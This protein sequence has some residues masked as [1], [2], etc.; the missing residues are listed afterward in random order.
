MQAVFHYHDAQTDDQLLTQAVVDSA[1]R[2]GAVVEYPARV[3]GLVQE[4]HACRVDYM[5]GGREQSVSAAAVVN[6]AGPWA[7]EVLSLARPA[8]KP[9]PVDL[10]RGT[11][12]V[13]AGVTLRAFYYLESPRD[14]RA[15]FAMPWQGKVLAGTT[16]SKFR[17]EP[18]RVKPLRQE[19]RYL[20]E[21]VNHYFPLWKDQPGTSGD[22]AFA[23]LRVLPAGSGHAF[24]RSREIRLH[25]ACSPTG[26]PV[27]LLTLY[28][29]KLTVWRATAE[30]VM[31]RIVPVLPR[32][33]RRAEPRELRL[34]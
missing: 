12:I 20:H 26:E 4:T 14:G 13:L 9:L 31:R 28:G 11:H 5:A 30:K 21:I 16:E 32:R 8:I 18:D 23:G 34:A 22:T 27:R 7:N 24:H 3:V 15:V 6:A 29:G 10:V 19:I 33:K 25:P 2:L 1:I 17:G